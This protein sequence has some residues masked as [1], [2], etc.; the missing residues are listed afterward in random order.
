MKN[1]FVDGIELPRARDMDSLMSELIEQSKAARPA[2]YAPPVK[3]KTLAV[4]GAGGHGHVVADAAEET[5][6][7]DRIVFYDDS[8]DRVIK[9][10]DW[11]IVG[12]IKDLFDMPAKDVEVV[13]AI[14]NNRVRRSLLY[15]LIEAGY[16]AAIVIHPSASISRHAVVREGTVVLAKAVVNVGAVVGRG[17][18]VNTSASVDHDCN[19]GDAVHISPGANLAGNVSVG[20]E[21]WIGIAACVREG[22]AVD[23]NVVV[24]AGSV[25]VKPVA[26]GVTVVGNPIRILDVENR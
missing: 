8:V 15:R 1:I 12:P 5:G 16:T 20:P 14:G 23:K 26:P 2:G 24:G 6:S 22:I 3:L 10:Q 4:I 19:L 25:V 7:W 17:C 11:Q 13:V 21:S 9:N 18:I